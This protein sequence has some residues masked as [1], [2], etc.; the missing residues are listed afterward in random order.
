MIN[1]YDVFKDDTLNCYQI[2]TKTNSYSVEFDDSE[3]EKIFLLIIDYLNKDENTTYL[4][5]KKSIKGDETKILDVLSLLNEYGL[6]SSNISIELDKSDKDKSFDQWKISGNK[7]MINEAVVSIFGI[8]YLTDQIE[9]LI[10]K[11]NFSKVK[12]YAFNTDVN[13]EKITIESDF[14]IVDASHWSPSDIEIINEFTIKHNKPWLHIGGIEGYAFKI[15]PLFYGDRTGC[16]NCLISRILSNHDFPEFLISY[17][18][19]LTTN[20]KSS[21]RDIIFDE[22]L[23]CNILANLTVLELKKYFNEWSLPTTWRTVLKIE[24]VDFSVSKHKLLKKPYCEV[25][26]PQILYN[27]S[28][29]LEAI[30]L[31]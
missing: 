26:N 14:I 15:G 9:K 2:R 7:K 16:Y 31:K 10:S 1:N 20:N 18:N 6:L 27:S 8:G 11:E 4:T 30:T 24:I 5:L 3:S 29:W 22:E 25:C 13:I 17:K 23:Y 12:K 19:Y 21:K 28:P